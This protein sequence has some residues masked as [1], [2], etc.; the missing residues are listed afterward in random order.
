M[1]ER[2]RLFHLF[3]KNRNK[4]GWEDM[5]ALENGLNREN[6]IAHATLDCEICSK[7]T[8]FIRILAITEVQ[9]NAQKGDARMMMP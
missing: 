8:R 7:A 6:G 1:T 3:K 5:S 2:S 4:I 9:L